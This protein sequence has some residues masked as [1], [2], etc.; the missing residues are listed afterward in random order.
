MIISLS[1]ISL[2]YCGSSLS[3]NM[4]QP[5]DQFDL[6]ASYPTAFKNIK[7]MY[8]ICSI[9]PILS[10]TG[11]L[12]IGIFTIARTS[13]SMSQ[14]G[15]F[16]KFLSHINAKT[17]VADFATITSLILCVILVIFIDVPSLVGF[18]DVTSFLTYSLIGVGILVI[19]YVHEDLDKDEP[20]S[21]NIN[22][23]RNCLEASTSSQSDETQNLL[24]HSIKKAW[25]FQNFKSKFSRHSFFRSKINSL[26]LI[27]YIYFSNITL[28]GLLNLFDSIKYV[29][30]G[31]F[32]V[33]NICSIMVLSIFKQSKA[34]E[35]LAF[36]VPLVPI[37]PILVIISNN[38]LLMACDLTE[39]G[40]FGLVLVGGKNFTSCECNSLPVV[41]QIVTKNF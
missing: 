11:S 3:L 29:L 34:S 36:K 39:W 26:F 1:I 31:L 23:T 40:I 33:N 15:L 35:S 22:T 2:V 6:K 27:I 16:F 13:L 28:F 18:S 32:V 19:R 9:G 24:G 41:D 25:G 20:Y 12:L 4:M 5:F 8:W 17:Q 38:Y 30:V 37:I 14:D 10:L 21:N 7:F